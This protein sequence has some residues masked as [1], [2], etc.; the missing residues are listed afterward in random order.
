LT[1][2]RARKASAP[3]QTS[4]ACAAD[5]TVARSRAAGRVE[6]GHRLRAV[7]RRAWREWCRAG[8][9]S[10]DAWDRGVDRIDR[11]AGCAGIV[12]QPLSPR[13]PRAR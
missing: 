1:A 5:R 2:S 13:A 4:K 9:S 11:R 8:A 3:R 6:A 12:S 7:H 10:C